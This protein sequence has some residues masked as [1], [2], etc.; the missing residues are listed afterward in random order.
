MVA[1]GLLAPYRV[2]DLSD[3]RGQLCGQIL[4]DLGADVI[5]IEPPGGSPARRIP[6]FWH[7]DLD[8]N[9]SLWW[10]SF[11]RNKRGI[12]LDVAAA[13]GRE[14][15]M[16]LVRTADFVV[17]SSDPGTMERAGLDYEALKT[18][19]P[20]VV[21]VSITPF[22]QTG[23]KASWSATDLTVFAASGAQILTG[24]QDRA[25]L[26]I[27][28]PQAF[29]H[30][31]SEAAA[32]AMIAH[33]ARERDGIGQHVDVSAQTASMIATQSTILQAA[34]NE[35]RPSRIGK[36]DP[37]NPLSL[38]RNVHAC[39]DG[40]VSITFLFGSA[41]GLFTRRLI[42]WMHEEGVVA[43]A[44][45]DKDWINYGSLVLSG[46]EPAS[47]LARVLDA[48]S[49]FTARRT[50]AELFAGAKKRNLLISPIN[51]V[52][53]TVAARQLR[54]RDYWARVFHPELGEEV[55]Y[56]GPFARFSANPIQFRRRPPLLGEHNAEI[57]GGE[58][59]L[60]DTALSAL[61]AAGVI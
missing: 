2:L 40:Y 37:S 36:V 24:Y 55:V 13:D 35:R 39:S 41:L 58:L 60:N 15:F 19:N 56:P 8:P 11:N 50:K 21:L 4:G 23:P 32:A 22:G 53:D 16:R 34:W 61:H 52:A 14:L 49:T 27:P 1:S 54:D 3:E 30:A 46:E 12:T 47:E 59:G 33:T 28:V 31:A 10:W 29:L 45:R 57:L 20:R 5:A 6:P 42:E 9:K 48:I 38:L 44:T 51:S 17:E 43:E 26:R 7:D 25:P 18:T